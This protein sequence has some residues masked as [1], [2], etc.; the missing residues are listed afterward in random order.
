MNSNPTS[1]YGAI[2]AGIHK[3]ALRLNNR[4]D[5]EHEQAAV[6]IVIQVVLLVYILA[7]GPFTNEALQEWY[8]VLAFISCFILLASTL[9]ISILVWPEKSPLRRVIGIFADISAFSIGMALT[10]ELGA[11]WY[12][13]YLWVTFGNGFRYGEKYLYL[14]GTLSVIGFSIVIASTPYWQ[15]NLPLGIGLLV[16]LIVLPGYAAKLTK[17]IH[18][19]RRRAEAANQAKSEFLARMSHEIRTPL[20]G[21]IGT[22]ELLKS[23]NL[24]QIEREY[25][26][27]VYTSGHTLLRLIEDILDISKIEAGKLEIERTPFDLYALI[28]STVKML[29]PQVNKRK[30]QLFSHIDPAIPFRLIGDPLHLRQVLINLIGNAIKFTEE[31]QVELRCILTHEAGESRRVRFEVIDSGIGIPEAIQDKIFEKFT[32][33]DG[34]TTR[35]FGGTG[36]GTTIAKQLVELMDGEIGLT[37]T[38]GSGS[39]FWF[40]IGFQTQEKIVSDNEMALIQTC[41]VLRISTLDDTVETAATH[42]LRGWG[43]QITNCHNATDATTELK[44]A[45]HESHPYHLLLFEAIAFD[46]HTVDYIEHMLRGR[47]FHESSIL[48]LHDIEKEPLNL[49]RDTLKKRLYILQEPLEK[50][51]LFNILHASQ[52]SDF[53]GSHI[54]T[55]EPAHVDTA[56]LQHPLEILIAE[57]NAINR[58]VIGRM[59]KQVG[60]HFQQVEDGQELLDALETRRYD[61]VIVDMQMPNLGGLDAFKI[62]R[63]AHPDNTTPF[64]ILTANATIESRKQCEEAGIKWFLT[65]PVSA[66]RLYQTIQSAVA[67]REA[68]QSELLS[69]DSLETT[70]D[71]AILDLRTVKE[72][73]ML[74]PDQAFLERLL[75][76][77]KQD[78]EQ[79]IDNMSDAVIANNSVQFSSYAHALK[80]SAANLGL[81]QLQAQALFAERIPQDE[82]SE[83]GPNQITHLRSALKQGVSELSKLIE[84]PRPP[85]SSS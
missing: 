81:S 40:D 20:N 38:P 80:G 75:N 25:V 52:V 71:D 6:R 10:G 63:F 21:I 84:S 24:N 37:S 13:V 55:F 27:T 14:S 16:S 41:R 77:L 1:I 12:A 73:Y 7:S 48:L 28:N 36:L 23:C 26:D 11:P 79:L 19:E 8:F 60:H 72:L 50:V 5:S 67:D 47:D 57:D 30:V 65:K 42:C 15:E 64:I 82:L 58:L 2:E 39:T 85:F 22:G 17:R 69:E 33:A 83:H 56:S 43:V 35:R 68:S 9:F 66:Q 46:Q 32:Q 70:D 74:A 53:D 31:G 4:P 45:N 49:I 61:L 76:K 62:F 54:D 3:L 51:H 29:A 78:G 18:Q 34:S 59:L 44:R